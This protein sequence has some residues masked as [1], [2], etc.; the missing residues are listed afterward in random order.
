MATPGVVPVTVL[1]FM[2]AIDEPSSFRRSRDVW[3]TRRRKSSFRL[4][5]DVVMVAPAGM[6]IVTRCSMCAIGRPAEPNLC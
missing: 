4:E 3:P 6:P 1:S 5:A 2:T